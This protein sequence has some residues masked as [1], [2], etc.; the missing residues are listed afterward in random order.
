MEHDDR[1]VAS[2]A[3]DVV[4]HLFAVEFFAVVARHQVVHNNA[5][6]RFDCSGLLPANN[7]MRRTEERAVDVI[8]SL[9]NVGDITLRCYDRALKVVH[10]VI[11]HAVAALDD[12]TKRVGMLSHVVADHKERSLNAVSVERIE[13]PGSNFRDGTIVECEVDRLMLHRHAPHR[14]GKQHAVKQWWLF[15]KHR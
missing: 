1:T 11:A 4:E 14:F 12:H 5:H 8:V 7:A 9:G 13:H 3:F 10:G 6:I 15:D 2:E